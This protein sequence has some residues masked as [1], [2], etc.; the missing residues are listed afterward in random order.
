MYE[1]QAR[2]SRFLEIATF[3]KG[4]FSFVAPEHYHIHNNFQPGF[5]Y[6]KV[7]LYLCVNKAS[8]K[9]DPIN[10]KD[11]SQELLN[12][13]RHNTKELPI[14]N[15]VTCQKFAQRIS[16]T[17][18]SRSFN[19]QTNLT[20]MPSSN[21]Y[22]YYDYSIP[23]E[24]ETQSMK[25]YVQ[26][27]NHLELLSGMNNHDRL[28]GALGILPK[29]LI[30]LIRLTNSEDAAKVINDLRFST[31]WSSYH[32]WSKRQTLNRTYWKI[33]PECCLPKLTKKNKTQ[34]TKRRRRT[35]KVSLED[36]Q[37]PFHYL[38]MKNKLQPIQGTCNCTLRMGHI[39]KPHS[40]E[41]KT[42]PDHLLLQ[43]EKEIRS[44]YNKNSDVFEDTS[45][46]DYTC[47]IK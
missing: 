19:T 29:H 12:W 25:T 44:R 45:G 23:P 13:S 3:P 33:I 10:W 11:M 22:H 41:T 7:G 39:V 28:A 1:T 46:L 2:K 21:F 8:L 37:N 5:F 30:Q 40:L 43:T 36:C 6:D 47:P 4:S 42:I 35:I 14:I 18:S 31:F 26:N 20:F 27:A 34:G 24:D 16:P 38:N 15:S 17:H 32:I 9:I